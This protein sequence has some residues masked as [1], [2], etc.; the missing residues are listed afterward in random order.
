MKTMALEQGERR[1]ERHLHLHR[2]RSREQGS[3]D[4]SVLKDET[5]RAQSRHHGVE[6]MRDGCWEDKPRISSMQGNALDVLNGFCLSI[7]PTTT[8]QVLLSFINGE[9]KESKCVR[10]HTGVQE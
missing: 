1:E 10:N 8:W 7:I 2:L 4:N 6:W 3:Q 5:S 9:S